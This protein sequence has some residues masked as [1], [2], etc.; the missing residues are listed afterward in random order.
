MVLLSHGL[1]S[2]LRYCGKLFE[3]RDTSILATH[4]V[5]VFSLKSLP[6]KKIL[7]VFLSILT[8]FSCTTD[9]EIKADT[10][11]HV[12]GK[13][14][15]DYKNQPIQNLKM[16]VYKPGSFI[17]GGKLMAETTTDS[18]GKYSMSFENQQETYLVTFAD[19]NGTYIW[20][21]NNWEF[22]LESG[23]NNFDFYIRAA[24]VFKT[25]INISNNIYGGMSIYSGYATETQSIHMATT[26]TTL[27]FKADPLGP[28][29]F[30]MYVHEI[31]G[32]YWWKSELKEWEGTAD[33][34]NIEIDAD[35]TTFTRYAANQNPGS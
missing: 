31:D 35:V 17:S 6:M 8:L 9:A 19:P 24:K 32:H 5:H 20:D 27:Y 4:V 29:I 2:Y 28:N 23:Y 15:D 11:I 16:Y 33:T 3:I 26:D 13:V 25:K 14:W 10:Q 1:L 30:Q 22:F 34:L 12:N 21:S 7:I 18:N